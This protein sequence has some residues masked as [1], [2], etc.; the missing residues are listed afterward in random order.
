MFFTNK[1]QQPNK[2][3]NKVEKTIIINH[4]KAPKYI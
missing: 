4:K 1:Q 2:Q 3:H